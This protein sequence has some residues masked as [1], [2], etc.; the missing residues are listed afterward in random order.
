MFGMRSDLD[1]GFGKEQG[2]AD[3]DSYLPTCQ[4]NK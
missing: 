3:V 4:K 1:G 2:P